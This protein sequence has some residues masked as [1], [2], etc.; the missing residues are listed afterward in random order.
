M[1]I[2][3]TCNRLQQRGNIASIAALL[4][5]GAPPY[6]FLDIS[7]SKLEL[8]RRPPVLD[9]LGFRLLHR[10]V[11]R[12]H[13]QDQLGSRGLGKEHTKRLTTSELQHID[14]ESCLEFVL[15]GERGAA[16][17]YHMDVLNGTWVQVVSRFK[18]WFVPTRPVTGQE[19]SEFGEIRDACIPPVHLF[20]AVL[21]RPRDTL[22]I[23]SGYLIPHFV[24]TGEDSLIVGGMEWT[25]DS[26]PSDLEQLR[27]IIPRY[28]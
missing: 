19:A 26:V 14:L 11:K 20:R 1:P 21:L 16:S 9:D 7:G 2:P 15:L 5:A 23:R 13:A 4:N 12:T 6:N 24:R 17:R 28:N 3:E 27:F 18:L 22:I 10:T 25:S 8:H